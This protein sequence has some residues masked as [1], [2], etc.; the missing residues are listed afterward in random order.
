MNKLLYVSITYALYKNKID[1]QLEAWERKGYE[2]DLLSIETVD[3]LY[4][5]VLYKND[6]VHKEIT[7]QSYRKKEA[8]HEM[9][10]I[11]KEKYNDRNIV[12]YIRRLGINI[13]YTN[14]FFASS[15]ARIV[16]EIPTYPIDSG[17]NFIKKIALVAETIYFYFFVY[18][19][20]QVV[21]ACIQKET[22]FLPSKYEPIHNAVRVSEDRPIFIKNDDCYTLLFIGNLQPWHGL[23]K[24]IKELL[25]YDGDARIKLNIY[26]SPTN[27]YQELKKK[28]EE[29]NK[30]LFCG[31]CSIS[32]IE[33]NINSKTIGIGGLE[34]TTRGAVCDTSLKNK[35]YASL[36]IPF[37]FSLQDLSFTD[38]K[39]AY[40]ISN[41]DFD[42]QFIDRI[43]AW[44]NTIYDENMYRII[45][46]YARVNL[47]YDE[48]IEHVLR[49]L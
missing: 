7:Y 13:I 18:P 9:F 26:S 44:Y 14:N 24:V 38:Y 37:I 34:Y 31:S 10:R 49:R 33:K 28:Y 19:Y 21:P 4:V 36:G 12:I 46:Q 1:G 6:R 25:Y 48:Q 47:T 27:Y 16:Y 3:D 41:T 17:T 2:C 22:K 29:K 20:L 5:V 11:M 39:Y 15:K 45:K 30:I 32:N 23:E 8:L 43:I 42:G 40:R 35:D